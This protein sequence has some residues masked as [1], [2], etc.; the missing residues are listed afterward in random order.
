M[1]KGIYLNDYRVMCFPDLEAPLRTHQDFVDQVQ[2]EHHKGFCPLLDIWHLDLIH[3][4]P[5]DY[6]HLVCLGVMK[7]L[8]LNAWL[9][10][11]SLHI[12]SQN[13]IKTFNSAILKCA[14][15]LPDDFNRKGRPLQEIDHWKAMELRTFLLYTGPVVL[16][17]VLS[18]TKYQHFLYFHA[19][20]RI[21]MSP[22]SNKEQKKKA[23][24]FLKCFSQDFGHIYGPQHMV[25]NVHSLPHVADDAILHGPL[26]ST[27]S[28]IYE[29]YLGVIDQ[30]LQGPTRPLA[31]L[32]RRLSEME[33]AQSTQQKETYKKTKNPLA[34][35][36]P[37]LNTNMNNRFCL[38]NDNKCVLIDT[39]N[40]TEV[41]GSYL[42][43]V[44]EEFFSEPVPASALRIFLVD[45][46]PGR[47]LTWPISK[48]E[49]CIKCVALEFKR[50]VSVIIPM[51]H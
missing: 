33:Y 38:T 31:Q 28:F 15:Q 45:S 39:F 44:E 18:P 43:V 12:F 1:T 4:F 8:L 30:I 46:R 3:D 17:K 13:Q 23:G 7:R 34:G 22:D 48:F 42:K 50:N 27:G 11:E 41:K 9:R 26:D 40:E 51:F 24:E 35:L 2:E 20:I 16:K 47:K 29:S 25:Y 6:M 36:K 21:L 32:N 10:G 19:G 49:N 37:S 14:K 5:L